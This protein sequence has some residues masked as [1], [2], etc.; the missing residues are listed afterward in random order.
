M[1]QDEVILVDE[2]DLALGFSEKLAAHLNGGQL[3]RAFSVFVFNPQGELLLQQRAAE[4]Y[5]FGQLWTNTCCSHPR[6]G[7]T[8]PAAA[9]RR[10]HEELGFTTALTEVGH[11][12]YR[13]EDPVS[14]LT[15]HELDHVFVGYYDAQ[16]Q[17]N[18]DEVLAFRWQ[19]LDSVIRE[20]LTFPERFTPWF[21]LALAFVKE[22][23]ASLPNPS[24]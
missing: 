5:H 13:A 4:K 2:S 15:E 10:L 12:V 9:Q 17:P 3:H 20:H 18:P 8:T 21:P 19:P 16:P 22:H 23:L 6:P 7:E 14:G 1:M 24:A 11:F